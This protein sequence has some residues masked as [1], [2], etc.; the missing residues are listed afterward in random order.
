MLPAVPASALR[1]SGWSHLW[2]TPPLTTTPPPAGCE[3]GY[4]LDSSSTCVSTSSLVS[5]G[6]SAG[7]VDPTPEPTN[8]SL[9]LRD[10]SP[11][12]EAAPEP[13]F[14]N[15]P[16]PVEPATRPYPPPRRALSIREELARVVITTKDQ[17][18]VKAWQVIAELSQYSGKSVGGPIA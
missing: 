7:P 13:L 8:S 15:V 3:K 14:L 6:I 18:K 12:P 11:E 17:L 16:S 10:A 5:R 9:I 4:K 1:V 2:S